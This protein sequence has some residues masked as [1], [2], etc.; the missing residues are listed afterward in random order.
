MRY[1]GRPFHEYLEI[2]E[3]EVIRKLRR[4]FKNITGSYR[5]GDKF[6]YL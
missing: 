3:Y 1:T 4:V 2:R 5:S 6:K